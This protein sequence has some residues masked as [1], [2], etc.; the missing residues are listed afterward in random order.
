MSG[1]AAA[2]GR[3]SYRW[4]HRVGLRW[5][6]NDAY[7]H[8][9]NAVHYQWFDSAVNAWLV[10]AGLL[11]IAAGD[12]IG[13]VVETGCR[14]FAALAYPGE[15]EVGI[16]LDRLGSSSVTYRIGRRER[17]WA[18]DAGARG[19][20]AAQI[21]GGVVG[22]PNLVAVPGDRD[23]ALHRADERVVELDP[24]VEHAHAHAG[25]GGAAP[26]PFAR[27]AARPLGRQVDRVAGGRGQT[28]GG[29]HLLALVSEHRHAT[30]L[31]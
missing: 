5:G 17:R 20:V 9:N 2:R 26:G 11:D 15:V 19:A 28:P 16:A 29:E 7:G 21:A 6:D 18:H 22:D 24:A 27:D 1:R 25:P 8:V 14:Y 10:E 31:R 4:W 23:R 12:P 30:I 13:L 3:D